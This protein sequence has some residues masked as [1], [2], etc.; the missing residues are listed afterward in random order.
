MGRS[1]AP[2]FACRDT[3]AATISGTAASVMSQNQ[4]GSI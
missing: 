1:P 4:V 3:A 2:A